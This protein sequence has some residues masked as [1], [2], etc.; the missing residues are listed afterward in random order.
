MG[1]IR[2]AEVGRSGQALWSLL[3]EGSSIS[4]PRKKKKK[5]EREKIRLRQHLAWIKVTRP[6]I[7]ARLHLREVR[8]EEGVVP[9]TEGTLCSPTPSLDSRFSTLDSHIPPSLPV[10][11]PF[12]F[13]TLELRDLPLPPWGTL[14]SIWK[15]AGAVP[16]GGNRAAG[17][18]AASP[19]SPHRHLP[20][21]HSSH[22]P[23]NGPWDGR[24]RLL[25]RAQSLPGTF[26]PHQP[27]HPQT[28][29]PLSSQYWLCLRPL[30]SVET[31]PL[32]GPQS[33]SSTSTHWSHRE[34][35]QVLL[36]GLLD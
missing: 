19:L 34:P 18:L 10:L 32:D 24:G 35:A 9:V 21:F 14:A 15:V 16:A 27:L 22:H 11:P 3:P 30:P 8:Q 13:P 25:P 5:K 20:C 4:F 17:A 33:P 36:L 7:L 28:V 1:G 29:T 2:D 12:P 26:S 31:L 6:Q 23:G